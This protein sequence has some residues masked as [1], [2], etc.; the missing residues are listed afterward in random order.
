MNKKILH[1]CDCSSFMPPFFDFMEESFGLSN[2]EFL[3]ISGVPTQEI[4]EY[5]N[6]HLSKKTVHTR[7]KYYFQAIIKINQADKIILHGLFDFKVLLLLFFMPW[8]LIRC[9]WIMWGNDLYLYNL[10]ERNWKWRFKE[11]FR[12]P[13]IKHI[14][15]FSTTVPG[16]YDLAKEWYG[17]KGKFIHNLMYPSHLARNPD[18]IKCNQSKK[19]ELFIQVGNSSDP[20]NNHFDILK[21][22]SQLD[23]KDVKVFCPLSY[24]S[25]E[26]RKRVIN[27]GNEILGDKFFPITDYMSFSEYNNYM[28]CIDIAIFNHDRQQGMGNII[29]LL[30]LGK[31]VVLK[32][33]VTPMNFFREIDVKLYETDDDDILQPLSHIIKKRNIDLMRKYFSNERL[34]LNWKEVFDGN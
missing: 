31:K 3:I 20:S 25:I 24:G 34:K 32:S 12:R 30:S 26:H 15:Y 11:F 16:D 21:R 29:G 22:L 23:L 27:Y 8:L 19:N 17:I 1:I 28:A 14:G 9:Y 5:N 33:N 18:E 6:I 2:H 10:G 13:V 4:K 7:L